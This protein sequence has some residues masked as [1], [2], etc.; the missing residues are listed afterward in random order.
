MYERK[1][2]LYDKIIYIP[3]D[4]DCSVLQIS[5]YRDEPELY[6]SLYVSGYSA[7]QNAFLNNLIENVKLILKIVIGKR[8]NLYEVI[9]GQSKVKELTDYLVSLEKDLG[10]PPSR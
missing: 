1:T 4:C 10:Q 7:Y 2:A 3:C 8:Y 6:I 5:R 9:V